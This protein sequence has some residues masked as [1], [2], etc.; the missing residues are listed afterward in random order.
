M[1]CS[2]PTSTLFTPWPGWFG[3]CQLNRAA[4][5]ART[6]TRR[7]A[8]VSGC[9]FCQLQTGHVASHSCL[10]DRAPPL[11]AVHKARPSG[12]TVTTLEPVQIQPA[13]EPDPPCLP[14][15]QQAPVHHTWHRRGKTAHSRVTHSLHHSHHSTACHA[16]PF[17]LPPPPTH[18][19]H[20]H[21]KS[22]TVCTHTPSTP[23]T[24]LQ[25]PCRP[26]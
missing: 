12:H 25:L 26:Q 6:L 2:Q 5:P 7:L 24:P 14:V 23:P 1:E 21:N 3:A 11:C 16:P 17:S 13:A 10:S 9:S 15:C 18:K 8:Q 19:E 4:V 20:T 22:V